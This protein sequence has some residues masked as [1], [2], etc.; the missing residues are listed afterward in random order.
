M[1]GLMMHAPLTITSL[2]RHAEINHADAPIAS[3]QP[4]GSLHRYTYADAF[5]RARQLAGALAARGI[6]PGDRIGTL[7]WNDFRH[8]ELY[9]GV[10]C[11]GAIAHTINPR[12]F[13]D[14]LE[15]II[16]DAADRLLF[17][18]PGILPV[19]EPLADRLDAVE[20]IIV[21]ADAHEMPDSPLNNLECYE[22][23]IAGQPD[24]F[25]W[26]DL[27]ELTAS[28]LCYTSGTTGNPKGV[29]YSH[30]T[31]VLHALI[32]NVADGFGFSS[33]D[34]VMP[35]V[36]MFHVN[37]WGMPYAA[38][39]TGAGLVFPGAGM[40]DGAVLSGLIAEEG[41]T[42]SAGVPTIWMAVLNHLRQSGQRLDSLNTV[43]IGGSACPPALMEELRE[44]HGVD[45]RHAWGM[46]EMSPLGTINT[47]KAGMAGASP[48]AQQ[49]IRNNQGRCLY[50][51]ELKIED[52]DGAELPRDGSATGYLKTRGLCVCSGYY[53]LEES[54]AHANGWF[55]TGDIA[56]IDA[57]G[58]LNITDRSKDVIKSGGEWISSIELENAAVGHPDIQEAA[59]IAVD[60]A[61]WGERPL[62]IVV[63]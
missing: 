12:L 7:A 27:D 29:L 26:P 39:M 19:I 32:S 38:P 25:E 34:V 23:F 35:V 48:E 41:V 5:R 59:V 17:V 30:R 51:V 37:A 20:S 9:Y 55:D 3:R 54:S 60:H 46:T 15:F 4:D 1:H 43:L 31:T 2:L 63:P 22:T 18:D 50:G 52:D 10:S 16:N 53:G 11:S 33:M 47:L 58:Y 24:T 56:S 40:G 61:K 42:F 57:D 6:A 36:P 14:Q 21:L 45:V 13:A 28:S 44:V 49:A 8:F 62:L